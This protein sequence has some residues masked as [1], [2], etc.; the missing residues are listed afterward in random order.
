VGAVAE[1]QA[2]AVVAAKIEFEATDIGTI[3]E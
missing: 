2:A 3:A 1:G